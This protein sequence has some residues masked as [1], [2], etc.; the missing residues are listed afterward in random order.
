MFFPNQNDRGTHINISGAG[1]T[2]SAKNKENA[3]KL[4][5]YM[6]LDDAQRWYSNTN[7]EYPAKRGIA[8]SPELQS[9]G[10]FKSDELNL[11]ALGKNNAQAV[12]IM[13]KVGWK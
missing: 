1:V 9:W 13:D 5:E 12:M 2:A 8:A 4:L 6:A 10:N 11:S 7:G 3:V